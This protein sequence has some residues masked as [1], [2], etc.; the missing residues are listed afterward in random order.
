MPRRK[1]EGAGKVPLAT[2]PSEKSPANLV[3]HRAGAREASPHQHSPLD[4]LS[5]SRSCHNFQG[6]VGLGLGAN[7]GK[8]VQR[9]CLEPV[10]EVA[11]Q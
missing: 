3:S 6:G 5:L 8:E 9:S 2:S 10:M 7:N 4:V 11:Q 1:A